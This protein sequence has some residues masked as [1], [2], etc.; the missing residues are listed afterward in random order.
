[1]H[2]VACL[3]AVL[4]VAACAKNPVTGK[5][6]LSLVSESQEIEMGKQA[7]AEV[8]ATMPRYPDEK[9]QAYV[10]GLGMRIAKHSE[11][12]NLPWSFTVLDDS[13]VNAFAL[14][15]GPI[16]I[17]RGI[18]TH[19]NSEAELA[20]V[21]GHEIGHVTARHSVQQISKA[22]LAQ[23][24]LGLGAVLKPELAGVGQ[25]AGAGLQLLFLKYGRDAE[26]QSDELGFKYMVKEGWDPHE[27]PKMFATLERVSDEAGGGRAPGFLSTHPDPGDREKVAEKRAAEV[28]QPG[29]K[30]GRDEFLAM[31]NGMKFGEDPRQGFFK[32]NAFLHPDLKFK[33]DFPDG[34]KKQ[35]GAS[36]V[37]AVSPNDDAMIQLGSAG[38]VPPE[39]AAKKF[40]SQKGIQAGGVAG[41]SLAGTPG[42]ASY[43]Q[44]Q[45]EKGVVGGLVTFISHQGSTFGILGVTEASKLGAQDATFKKTFASFGTLTDPAALAVQA[46]K[47]ELVKVPRTMTVTEFNAQFPST[48]PIEQVAVVNGV[49]KDGTLQAG[50]NAKRIVGGPPQSAKPTAAAGH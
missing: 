48:A 32:G 47:I 50:Q 25:A 33:I 3:A 37:V 43:F 34:W 7:A 13:T 28:K 41:S 30:V 40:L 9:V 19:M 8:A 2:R 6:Q 16:F 42:T 14:P 35:N 31:V 1:M 36:A 22:Q 17:T 38:K 46:P 27:M 44:A 18:L 11:R 23:L 26:R 21:I 39:E 10:S 12:P 45:T 20:S 24:G 15:G 4:A 5:R 49:A 29:L